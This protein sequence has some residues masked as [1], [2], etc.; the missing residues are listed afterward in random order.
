VKHIRNIFKTKELEPKSTCAKIAQVARDGK[1][2]QMDIYNL[3][4]I[5]A[6]GYRV[7]SKRGTQFRIW[8]TN[9]LRDHLVRGFTLNEK[10]LKENK[11]RLRELESAVEL[12]E[13]AKSTKLLTASETAGLLTVITEYTRIVRSA[14]VLVRTKLGRQCQEA[15]QNVGR[16]VISPTLEFRN[17]SKFHNSRTQTTGCLDF[18]DGL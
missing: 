5:I 14:S 18:L 8:A 4:V 12:I 15:V 7:N 16:D 17:R 2:R 13:K 10:R 9:M 11:Q 1:T 3:D 6:V